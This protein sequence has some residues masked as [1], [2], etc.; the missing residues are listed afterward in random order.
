MLL[1][2]IRNCDQRKNP[3]QNV[4]TVFYVKI[5]QHKQVLMVSIIYLFCNFFPVGR[6]AGAGA[7]GALERPQGFRQSLIVLL[8]PDQNGTEPGRGCT[9][10]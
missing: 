2:K 10:Q 8:A 4:V 9:V 1:T 7:S 6:V 3:S 5:A